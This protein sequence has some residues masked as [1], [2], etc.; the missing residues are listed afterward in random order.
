MM[1]MKKYEEVNCDDFLWVEK[2]QFPIPGQQ[3]PPNKPILAIDDADGGYLFKYSEQSLVYGMP[4]FYMFGI[5][6]V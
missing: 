3:L 6:L 1:P 2:L 4:T 5:K